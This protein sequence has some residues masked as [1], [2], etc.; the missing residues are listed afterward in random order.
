MD[1]PGNVARPATA[2]RVVVPLSTPSPELLASSASDIETVELVTRAPEP[3]TTSTE[4][5]LAAAGSNAEPVICWPTRASA[6]WTKKWSAQAPLTVVT[7]LLAGGAVKL[8]PG[9]PLK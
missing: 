5:W 7:R 9:G 3:S 6:G 8:L 2:A 4:T 1:R